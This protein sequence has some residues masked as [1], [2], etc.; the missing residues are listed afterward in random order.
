MTE[1]RRE[2]LLFASLKTYFGYRQTRQWLQAVSRIVHGAR[3][4][5][6]VPLEVAIFPE[7]ASLSGLAPLFDR[8]GIGLGSQDVAPDDSGMQTGEVSARVLS[9]IGC[10]F[11]ELG[12]AERR[13]DF[14]ETD[15]LIARKLANT[16]RHGLVPLLCVGEE[17]DAERFAVEV[18]VAQLESAL[19][20]I[21]RPTRLIVAYEPI[22][23]IGGA[24][25][26]PLA[27]V[28]EVA[29]AVRRVAGAHPLV[30][31]TQVIYGGSA[32]PTTVPALRSAID[33]LFLGRF[34]HDAEELA[35]VIE[36]YA[37]ISADVPPAAAV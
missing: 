36:A 8:A 19:V 26:A 32:G 12:H 25:S 17:P 30:S 20:G 23:A 9:E 4:A 14:G 6:T 35:R 10:S 11:V 21:D 31:D 2:V 3:T 27:H 7:V 34:I 16:V 28:V 1:P 22:H 15:E 5:G 24:E 18:C 13:R 33:G 29:D 37:R